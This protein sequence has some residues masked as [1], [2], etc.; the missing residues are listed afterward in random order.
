ML[1]RCVAVFIS[2][3][4]AA[5]SP[6]AVMSPEKL[7][8]IDSNGLCKAYYDSPT[9]N[10]KAELVK[11]NALTEKEW[12]AVAKKNISIGMSET[13]MLCSW[14]SPGGWGDIHARSSANGTTKQY[15]YRV[16]RS[17]GATYVYIRDGK[18][19]SWSD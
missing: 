4:M 7:S 6:M 8:T 10:I 12:S 3:L 2:A 18:V 17:C 5:C 16:C 15:V 11:R 13:A 1:A 14:G 19:S 9:Q